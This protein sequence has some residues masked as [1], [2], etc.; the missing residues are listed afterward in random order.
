MDDKFFDDK[1]AI[2][3]FTNE[4]KHRQMQQHFVHYSDLDGISFQRL[5]WQG[6]KVFGKHIQTNKWKYKWKKKK[7]T[8]HKSWWFSFA[9]EVNWEYVRANANACIKRSDVNDDGSA[10]RT[11]FCT[12]HR[13]AEHFTIYFYIVI[14]CIIAI[15]RNALLNLNQSQCCGSSPRSL[16]FVGNGVVSLLQSALNALNLFCSLLSLNLYHSLLLFLSPY[17]KCTFRVMQ[18]ALQAEKHKFWL[19]IFKFL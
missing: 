12:F 14:M 8:K 5:R 17:V 10:K 16:R 6:A 15:G 18:S 2:I 11:Y 13:F 4:L 19:R 3:I 7:N 1:I 9:K